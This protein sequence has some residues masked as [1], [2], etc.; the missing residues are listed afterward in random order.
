MIVLTREFPVLKVSIMTVVVLIGMFGRNF[1]QSEARKLSFLA[2]DWSEFESL[3]PFPENTVLYWIELLFDLF[4][5]T[6]LLNFLSLIVGKS[7]IPII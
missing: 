1:D 6:F 5:S 7:P 4:L 2:S 3:R